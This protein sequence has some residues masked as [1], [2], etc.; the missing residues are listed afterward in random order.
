MQE[1]VLDAGGAATFGAALLIGLNKVGDLIRQARSAGNDLLLSVGVEIENS[2]ISVQIAYEK[3]LEKTM[4][5]LNELETKVLTDIDNII[6]KAI[7][8]GAKAAHD[9]LIQTQLISNSLPFHNK[10]PQVG[11]YS[12]RFVPPYVDIFRL[13][14]TGNF[15]FEFSEEDHPTLTVEGTVI[16]PI[17]NTTTSIAFNIPKSLL[18]NFPNDNVKSVV[19]SLSVPW[20]ASHWYHHKVKYGEFKIELELL[21]PNPGKVIIKHKV[22]QSHQES[23]DRYSDIFIFDSSDN[24][25]EED[26][27]LRL[28][29]DENREGWTIQPGT[30]RFDLVERMEGVEGHDWYNMGYQRGSDIEVVWRARTERKHAGSSGKIKWRI[31]C[32]I[33]RTVTTEIEVSDEVQISWGTSRI[34][35][36]QAGKWK[37]IWT[38]FDGYIQEFDRSYFESSFLKIDATGDSVRISA[39]GVMPYLVSSTSQDVGQLANR[40]FY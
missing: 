19:A 39:Y 5:E 17:L 34:F 31:A 6:N 7:T 15:P 14:I 13:D 29:G 10:I 21:P 9:L 18:G 26:R 27:S 4:D 24:D 38:R 28:S 16:Q 3:S 11:M 37:I 30:A 20:D 12:L 32:K 36:Y 22:K 23:S 25:I 8:E 1:Q 35:N 33:I 40:M 2:I